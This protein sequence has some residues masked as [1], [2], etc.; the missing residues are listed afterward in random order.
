MCT[1]FTR[2]ALFTSPEA[3]K[4]DNPTTV[5]C[6]HRTFTISTD[7]NALAPASLFNLF[8][9]NRPSRLIMGWKIRHTLGTSEFARIFG[10]LQPDCHHNLM[11]DQHD[12]EPMTCPFLADLLS[13]RLSTAQVVAIPDKTPRIV[14]EH[15]SQFIEL[16]QKVTDEAVKAACCRDVWSWSSTI[17]IM[18]VRSW[19]E[20]GAYWWRSLVDNLKS[21]DGVL[22][23]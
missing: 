8:S 9:A 7:A 17:E 20:A 12:D 11:P 4:P 18:P 13:Q 2:F 22:V 6:A 21:L 15:Y 5:D 16:Q 10:S 14:E 23:A 3:Q 1:F 19:R